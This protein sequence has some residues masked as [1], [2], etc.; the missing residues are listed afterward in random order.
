MS[1]KYL[2]IAGDMGLGNWIMLDGVIG[3]YC[4]ANDLRLIVFD[5]DNNTPTQYV[6]ELD[7]VEEI[8][9]LPKML[10]NV[11]FI[12]RLFQFFSILLYAR[13][14]KEKTLVF[15]RHTLSPRNL[16]LALCFGRGQS[17]LNVLPYDKRLNLYKLLGIK[18]NF[19]DLE[20]HEVVNNFA[21][22]RL[23]FENQELA[24]HPFF[25]SD[26]NFDHRNDEGRPEIIMQPLSS[27]VQPWKRWSLLNWKVLIEAML[28]D[29]FCV[30]VVGS[31][32]E[33][34]EIEA[35]TDDIDNNNL[36][37]FSGNLSFPELG[38]VVENAICVVT[39][40]GVLGHIASAL[41]T[42][43]LSL[44]GPGGDGRKPLSKYSRVAQAKCK[45]NNSRSIDYCALKKIEK[46]GGE[47]L[48]QLSVVIIK[49]QIYE[50]IKI[51]KEDIHYEQRLL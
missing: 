26:K 10:I 21:L 42:P 13:T 16:M 1:L 22:L 40:D 27:S 47:C 8:V 33:A 48:N 51:K 25:P 45:C 31:K 4:R 44:I 24:Y 15:G 37:V 46:C 49:A 41:N 35:I 30:S 32:G 14:I 34:R 3:P 5:F 12:K 29:G 19:Y 17:L 23:L 20:A 50:T 39:A 2:A 18:I 28:N 11:R 6:N 7:Y 43:S 36:R 38:N 9:F